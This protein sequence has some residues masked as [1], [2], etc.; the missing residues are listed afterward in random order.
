MLV[1]LFIAYLVVYPG[2]LSDHFFSAWANQGA[3]LAFVAVGQTLVVLSS[4]IDMSVGSIFALTNCIAS[5]FLNGDAYHILIALILILGAGIFCGLINGM[6]ISYTRIQPI[7][8]TIATGAVYYGI[9]L[10][11]RPVTGGSVSEALS[12]ALTYTIFHIPTSLVLLFGT[13]LLFWVLL[14]RTKLYIGIYAIGSSEKSAFMSGI[15]VRQAKVAAYM[16]SG[17]FASLG[18]LFLSLQTLTGDALIGGSYT[19]NSVAATVIGGTALVGGTGG[20]FGSVIGSYLLRTLKGL[21]FFAGIAPMAQPL[22]EGIVL[23]CA[24]S[25]GSVRLLGMKSKIEVFK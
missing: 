24:L 23:M 12:E 11:I 7:I 4:G 25:I 2:K 16:L 5:V 14:K 22:F 15:K 13:L 19:L 3:G 10:F 1:M 17:L 20:I 6:L 18:G 8:L 21:M 9:A